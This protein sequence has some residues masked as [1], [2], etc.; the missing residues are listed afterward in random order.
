MDK[1]NG[2]IGP[3]WT[4]L[5]ERRP[6]RSPNHMSRISRFIKTRVNLVNFLKGVS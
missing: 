1:R 2:T 5:V 6:L 3:G 4:V